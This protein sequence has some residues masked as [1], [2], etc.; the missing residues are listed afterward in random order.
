MNMAIEQTGLSRR[1]IAACIARSLIVEP[2]GPQDLQALRRIRRLQALGVNM[3]GIEIILRMRGRIERLYLESARQ[4]PQSSWSQGMH[5]AP[6]WQRLLVWEPERQ[7]ER[8][9]G[10]ASSVHEH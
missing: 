5:S 10:D 3:A 4:E 1:Q 6:A 8:V 7:P 2:L 9:D